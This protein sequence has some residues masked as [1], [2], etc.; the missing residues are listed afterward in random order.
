MENLKDLLSDQNH[1]ITKAKALEYSPLSFAFIG[2]SVYTLYVRSFL[3]SGSTAQAGKL[4]LLANDYVKASAQAKV[5][6]ALQEALTEEELGF[7]KRARNANA[8]SV[9]KN[10]SGGDYKKATAYEALLGYLYLTN[11]IT[12]LNEILVLSKQIMEN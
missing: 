1:K 2:D 6:D 8:K 12:R 9:A 7:A 11:Q 5:Y 10:A 3:V 4:H